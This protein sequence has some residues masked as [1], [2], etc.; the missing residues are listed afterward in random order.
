MNYLSDSE[1]S[2]IEFSDQIWSQDDFFF[3]DYRYFC[4]N[5]N[6]RSKIALCLCQSVYF[7]FSLLVVQF[8]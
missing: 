8:F 4:R 7:N 3:K 1:T 2:L 5:V 6:S